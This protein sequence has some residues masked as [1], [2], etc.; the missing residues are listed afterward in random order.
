MNWEIIFQG[1][2]VASVMIGP[3][4]QRQPT[5]L[6]PEAHHSSPEATDRYGVI[7]WE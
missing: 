7:T 4:A 3:P 2:A 6:V 1:F 5:R